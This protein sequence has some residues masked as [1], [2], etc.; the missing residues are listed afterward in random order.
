[1]LRDYSGIA[2]VDH[3]HRQSVGWIILGH[4]GRCTFEK[5]APSI[6]RWHIYEE[7]L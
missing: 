5:E 2:E 3:T 4:V 6:T 1:M 7:V